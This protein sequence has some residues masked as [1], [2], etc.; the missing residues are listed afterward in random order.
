MKSSS[1]PLK[2]GLSVT[3]NLK[4]RRSHGVHRLAR[5]ALAD[6]NDASDGWCGS[7]LDLK[8]NCFL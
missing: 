2:P 3:G 4:S 5:S 6:R 7:T 1:I 8:R